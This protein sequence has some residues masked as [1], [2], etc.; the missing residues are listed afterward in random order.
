MRKVL[1]A[2]A[3]TASLTQPVLAQ[4]CF[5]TPFGP[6]CFDDANS[7]IVSA[8][9]GGGSSSTTVTNCPSSVTQTS[10]GNTAT[11]TCGINQ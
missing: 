2:L 10:N 3:V 1:L 9:A 6:Q 11:A 8:T 7:I 5:D 4:T